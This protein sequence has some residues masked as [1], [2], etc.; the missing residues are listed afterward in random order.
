VKRLL[1]A[2]VAIVVLV[3][4]A[5]GAGG[6]YLVRRS[7]SATSGIV[8]ARGVNDPVEVVRD[9]WG[10]PHIYAKHSHDLFFTQGYVHAQDRLW[11]MELS[12]RTASGRLSELFGERTLQ[13]DRF[14]RTIGLRRIAEATIHGLTAEGRE[15]L[16]SYAQGVNA[17]INGPNGRL[18]IEFVLLRSR[19]EPWTPIDTLAYGK[20]VGWM[21]GGD[22]RAEILRQQLRA[23]FGDEGVRRLMPNYPSDAPIIIPSL[24][25]ISSAEPYSRPTTPAPWLAPPP[26]IG[27]NNW[28]VGGSRT[29]TR[30]PL[31]ANDPHLEASMP[32][33]WH[34]MHLSGAGYDVAGATFPGVPG[35]IIGHNRDIAWGV[36][37][38]NPDVQ[39][40][41]TVRFHPN[42]PTRYLDRDEW[43]T[44][45]MISETIKVKGRRTPFVEQVRWTRHGPIINP[46]VRGLEAT[47][48][49]RWTGQDS[50]T[51]FDAVDGVNRATTWAEFRSA[52]RLWDTPSLNFVF[53]HRT[54][55]IGYQMPG[56]VPI[57]T[58]GSGGVPVPGSNREFDWKHTIAFEQLPY[59]HA[60]DGT[61]I[62]ANNRIAPAGYPFFLGRE[63]DAGFRARR[64]AE[65]L[66]DG[67]ASIDAFKQIQGDV[68]SLPGRA[69]VEALKSVKISDPGLQPFVNELLQ[70]DGVL[71]PRSRPAAVYEALVFALLSELFKNPLD[72]AAF[73]RYLRH[74]D[75][76]MLT[77]LA[78][79]QE[80]DSGWWRGSRDEMVTTALRDAV[81]DLTKRLGPSH[82]Q[83]RWGRLHQPVFVHPLGRIK[84]LAWVFNVT[85]PEVGGDGFTVNNGGFDPEEPFQ[86]RIVA[87][88]RQILDVSNWDRSLVIH[89]TGQ[90]GLPFHKH[91]R[92]LAPMWAR[93]EYIP[94]LFSRTAVDGAAADR[95]ILTP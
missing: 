93:G 70:W 56:R 34:I 42:D 46:V 73:T 30:G 78:L 54:G 20:L 64:I 27:S 4:V 76:P 6:F 33:V 22:W 84:A 95:L 74:R 60:R 8:S 61:I 69:V 36:T 1:L 87:S 3:V 2:I 63:W 25:G 16:E 26:G 7:F 18:P 71:D 21:L 90:S 79:L 37:N 75:A 28:V 72:D 14:L 31:L 5:S 82:D 53:A 29:D 59:R 66:G 57:R 68:T 19:P 43:I 32:S 40:L 47:L 17:F 15:L 24:V 12:R 35:I 67:K 44:A 45:R 38:A 81:R 49:V 92:D 13:T 48:A 94:L 41:F 50:S 65:M 80:P 9:R 86:Q 85:P 23:R 91:Y 62:T 39:D 55:E 83:W 77:L 52:L 88:Y 89:T 11:Q 51:I 58:N 10:I